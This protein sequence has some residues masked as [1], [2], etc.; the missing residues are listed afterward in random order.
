MAQSFGVGFGPDPEDAVDV[1]AFVLCPA[2]AFA[3]GGDADELRAV[4]E[5]I[6][7]MKEEAIRRWAALAARRR[8]S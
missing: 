1:L 6:G 8:R 3:P 7:P 2:A 5:I 4:E